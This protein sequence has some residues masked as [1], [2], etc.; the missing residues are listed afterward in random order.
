MEW[1]LRW[2][3]DRWD[4]YIY[5]EVSCCG[6]VWVMSQWGPW[7]MKSG[8]MLAI[9]LTCKHCPRT[10]GHKVSWLGSRCSHDNLPYV[11]NQAIYSW[12][13]VWMVTHLGC[14][15][16]NQYNVTS[17]INCSELWLHIQCY[18]ITWPS[19]WRSYHRGWFVQ[20]VPS[21]SW[22]TSY[23]PSCI[24]RPD[25]VCLPV[26][27]EK[28]SAVEFIGASI[29]MSWGPMWLW[30][31]LLHRTSRTAVNFCISRLIFCSAGVSQNVL[32]TVRLH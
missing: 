15:G 6:G 13:F 12:W 5:T 29:K 25:H 17:F 30:N 1:W 27:N 31:H 24:P 8:L 26:R 3:S 19:V 20:V 23:R 28:W 16:Y 21:H 10:R 11:S 2:W 22:S 14:H 9:I 4:G 7:L 32:H 18:Y